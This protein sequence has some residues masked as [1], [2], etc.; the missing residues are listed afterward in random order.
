MRI[1]LF[2][3]FVHEKNLSRTMKHTRESEYAV[4]TAWRASKPTAENLRN[5]KKLEGDLNT[6]HYGFID[7]H[8][9]GQEHGGKSYEKSLMVVNNEK[10]EHFREVMLD[11]ASRYEQDFILYGKDGKTH[12][13]DCSTR[14]DVQTFTKAVEGEAEFYSAIRGVKRGKHAFH[15]EEEVKSVVRPSG[16]APKRT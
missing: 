11:L 9:V 6:M 4:L 16:P 2:E 13:V 1:K 5:M 12:L 14:E 10:R 15:L 3:D 7:M 8:G